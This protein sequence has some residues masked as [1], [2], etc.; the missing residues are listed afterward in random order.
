MIDMTQ[1]LTADVIRFHSDASAAAHLGFGCILNKR[2]IFGKLGEHFMKVNHPTVEFLE[3]FGHC[4]GILTWEQELRDCRIVVFCDNQ[5]VVQMINNIT[6]SCPNCMYLIR[7]LVLNGL[8]FNRR[9]FARY[10][11]M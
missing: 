3:L 10:I 7:I 9:V 1:N 6:S 4:A 5:A 8:K 2:R 11:S